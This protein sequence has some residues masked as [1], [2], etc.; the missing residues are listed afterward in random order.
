VIANRHLAPPALELEEYKVLQ[1]RVDVSRATQ[2]RLE[3]AGVTQVD[4]L[5][6]LQKALAAEIPS[7][8]PMRQQSRL[9]VREV[10]LH[11]VHG[12]VDAL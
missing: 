6:E 1:N 5:P 7:L 10:L 8:D 2:Q 11:R 4:L 9:K 12:G 3:Q